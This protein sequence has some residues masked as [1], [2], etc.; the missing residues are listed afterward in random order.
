MPGTSSQS[1]CC[2]NIGSL[3]YIYI[4]Y[5]IYIKKTME[6]QKI[7]ETKKMIGRN[8]LKK[9]NAVINFEEDNIIGNDEVI[10][11]LISLMF[12]H[13]YI[14]MHG[15]LFIIYFTLKLVFP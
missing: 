9:F 12:L 4:I 15:F 7:A 6:I 13:M 5:K 8:H 1:F 14:Y 2:A 3:K 11:F 10:N